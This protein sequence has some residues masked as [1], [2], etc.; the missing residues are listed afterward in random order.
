MQRASTYLVVNCQ[1]V[2]HKD[3]LLLK[4]FFLC[5]EPFF[6]P[7]SDTCFLKFS[8]KDWELGELKIS[9]CW[10]SHFDYFFQKKFFLQHPHENQSKFHAMHNNTL[11]SVFHNGHLKP[12]IFQVFWKGHKKSPTFFH[13]TESTQGE[14]F[15]KFCGLTIP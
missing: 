15:F 14:T 10:V 9:F 5:F 4:M 1:A 13:V 7:T 8:Q 11:Y 2:Q 12:L 3:N 6:E